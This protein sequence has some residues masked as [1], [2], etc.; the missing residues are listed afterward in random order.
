MSIN[1]ADAG[2]AAGVGPASMG[3]HCTDIG[4]AFCV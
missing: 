4:W 3:Q 2:R 1:P